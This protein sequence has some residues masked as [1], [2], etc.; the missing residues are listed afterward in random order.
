MTLTLA[1]GLTGCIPAPAP[2]SPFAG[3]TVPTGPPRSST[4]VPTDVSSDLNLRAIKSLAGRYYGNLGYD[5]WVPTRLEVDDLPAVVLVPGDSPT[6]VDQVEDLA[7]G[8][9]GAGAV[10][11]VAEIDTPGLGARHPEPLVAISCALATI[12][13]DAEGLGADPANI[14]L[15]GYDFGALVTMIVGQ[16]PTLFLADC[17]AASAPEA[18]RLVGVAGPYDL[19]QLAGVDSLTSYFGGSR[20]EQAGLWASGDPA[21]YLGRRPELPVLLVAGRT[22]TAVPFGIARAWA[23]DLS[24]AGHPV[25]LIGIEQAGHTSLLQPGGELDRVVEAIMRFL[26]EPLPQRPSE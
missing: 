10:V 12:Q 18:A 19:Q 9:A 11:M 6:G 24:E 16:D 2:E 20:D 1:L 8:L 21:E 26:R 4:T 25:E 3:E 17:P 23:D 13:R 14:T 15:V 22:D 5:V 7:A